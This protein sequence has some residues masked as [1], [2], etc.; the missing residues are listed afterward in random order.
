MNKPK[1]RYNPKTLRY[2]RVEF[3]V[4]RT[5]SSFIGYACFGAAFFVGLNFLQNWVIETNLEKTLKAENKALGQ[6]KVVLASAIENSQESLGELKADENTLQEKLFE[7]P[8]EQEPALTEKSADIVA[9]ADNWVDAISHLNVRAGKVSLKT[10]MKNEFYG[11]RLSLDKSDVPTLINFPS[12]APVK[13]L[14]D[15]NLVSG[16]GVRIN[17]FHKGNYHHDGIDI[18]LPRGTEILATGNGRVIAFSSH[19]FLQAGSGNYIEIDHGNG[20]VTRYSHLDQVNVSWGQKVTQGQVI[21]SAGSTGG[22]VAPHLHYEVIEYGK[23]LDPL[24]YIIE[25]ISPDGHQK[26]AVRSKTPNQSLD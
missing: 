6:Y 22:S 15:Q 7:S 17:P 1:F 3:S 23:N 16:F 8:V 21:G 25:D 13:N 19:D 2:E 9:S 11:E 18:A 14:N 4:W 24:M 26:L 20:L 10:R 12:I 5:L